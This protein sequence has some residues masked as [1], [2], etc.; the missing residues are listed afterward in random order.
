MIQIAMNQVEKGFS[1]YPI[2]KGVNFEI[3]D[4]ERIGIVGRNGCG[5][6]TL[7]KLFM[8]IET[9]D[10]GEVFIRKGATLGY[11]EQIP[12]YETEMTVK[13]VLQTAFESLN[14][15][16]RELRTL[17]E[18]MSELTDEAL[19]KCLARYARLSEAF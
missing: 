13:D 9:S 2:L 10:K 5:K 4:H 6:T 19:E 15:M 7:F 3:Q 16:A 14:E 1:I 11:V 8:G 18:K 17:E 12:H